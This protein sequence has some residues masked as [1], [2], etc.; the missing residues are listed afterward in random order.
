MMQLRAQR[1]TLKQQ[2]RLLVAS[3][4]QK[5]LMPWLLGRR[6]CPLSAD[7]RQAHHRQLALPLVADYCQDDWTWV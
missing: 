5:D 1:A 6:Q 4:A 2:P 3:F 7:H